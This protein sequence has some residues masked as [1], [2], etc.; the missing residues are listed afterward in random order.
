MNNE[1]KYA[2]KNYYSKKLNECSCDVGGTWKVLNSI[3]KRK[4]KDKIEDM[5]INEEIVND[6]KIIAEEFNKYFSEVGEKLARELPASCDHFS[7][8]LGDRSEN[9]FKFRHVHESYVKKI[10]LDFKDCSPGYDDLSMKVIKYCVDEIV[11][12]LSVIC[13]LSMHTGVFPDKL[14]QAQIIPIFKSNNRKSINNYRPISILPSISKIL[15]KIVTKQLYEFV[16][17]QNIISSSQYGF[18]S[19]RSTE[20]AVSDFT[21]SILTAFDD[22][23]YTI[24]TFIDLSKAFDTVAHDIL[25]AKLDHWGVRGSELHWIASYLRE[26]KI[27]VKIKNTQSSTNI[28]SLSVP[29][30][31]SL[32]PL[33]FIIY[34]NDIVNAS[35]LLNFTIY[36]DDCVTYVSNENL[37]TGEE[38]MNTELKSIYK[39]LL[40]NKLTINIQKTNF[41]ILARKK[42]PLDDSISI[43][44]N[45]LSIDRVKSI[46]FLGVT[47]NEKLNWANHIRNISKKLSKLNGV[48]Y[49][50]RH[51]LTLE[52]LKYLYIT[53]INPHLTYCNIIWG[54]TYK[55]QLRPLVISQKRIIRTITFNNRHAHTD[56]LFSS[57]KLMNLKQINILCVSQFVFKT[58]NEVIHSNV[59]FTFVSNIFEGNLRDPLRLRSPLL[60]STQHRQSIVS[61]GCTIWNKLNSEI[62]STESLV[63]FK[64]KIKN[65]FFQSAE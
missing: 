58:I 55:S 65:S 26:R 22:N 44:I 13:N 4:N 17:N 40:A 63:V 28:L 27:S 2:K 42:I 29:Q 45:N 18:R 53:L 14:K 1:I 33:L 50:V 23:Q 35:N 47:I 3:L 59:K 34:F 11:F 5:V 46:K 21:E 37:K 6:E 31:S 43:R 54:S 49:L 24:A 62:R 51:L 60:S 25:L 16:E 10:I 8:Y 19:G 41:M 9:V 30:G 61:H 15:E 38:I 39:W 20:I 12:P 48:F 36:A 32:G 52:T 64:R 57:L 56:P 7:Q